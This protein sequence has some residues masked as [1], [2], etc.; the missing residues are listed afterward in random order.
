MVFT[1]VFWSAEFSPAAVGAEPGVAEPSPRAAIVRQAG[2]EPVDT[3]LAMPSEAARREA[4]ARVHE[5]YR[6]EFSGAATA[7]RRR[8]LAVDLVS[9]ADSTENPADRWALLVEA[10]RLASDAGDATTAISLMERFSAEYVVDRASTRLEALSRLLPKVAPAQI[11]ELRRYCLDLAQELDSAENSELSARALAL[12]S[13]AVKKTKNTDLLAEASR[14]ALKQRERQKIDKEIKPLLAKLA[15][16]PDDAELCLEVGQLLCFRAGRWPE[17]L[18]LLVKGSDRRLASIARLELAAPQAS[19]EH[20][21][22][23]GAWWDWSEIQKAS[24]KAAAQSVAAR[25][26]SSA[27]A[28]TCAARTP[29]DERWSGHNQL[30]RMARS[31]AR[32]VNRQWEWVQQ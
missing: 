19:A 27:V 15:A 17:G 22:L 4:I 8:E 1:A 2:T 10:L 16:T 28:D 9:Q 13:A 11:E 29:H 14:M 31:D 12:A 6:E 20:V 7:M 18:E 24:T 32:K 30:G 26:Y 5:I 23:G 21:R 3:R 25:H